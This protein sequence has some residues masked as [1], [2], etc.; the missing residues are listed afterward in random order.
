MTTMTKTTHFL[1]ATSWQEFTLEFES[2]RDALLAT[3]TDEGKTDG[4]I[5]QIEE[6][7]FE[8]LWVDQAAAEEWIAG[9]TALAN[10]EGLTIISTE[11]NDYV[12]PQ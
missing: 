4:N 3:M 10:A 5:T 9:I 8:R 7:K 6:N 2:G 11:I 1:W 12:P